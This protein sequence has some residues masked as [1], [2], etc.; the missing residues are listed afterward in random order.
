M[1]EFD[2]L[3][4]VHAPRSRRWLRLVSI[5]GAAA[6]LGVGGISLQTVFFAALVVVGGTWVSRRAE[7]RGV[8]ATRD[9]LLISNTGRGV[10]V[11]KDGSTTEIVRVEWED[12]H[13]YPD[14]SPP[15]GLPLRWFPFPKAEFDNVGTAELRL[16]VIP[17]DGGEWVSVEAARGLMPKRVRALAA[18]IDAEIAS[19]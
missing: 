8:W 15:S 13:R 17:G 18:A 3:R 9:E 4:V 6:L 1:D 19:R 12:A 11:P 10:R 2:D 14:P 5:A 16:F 7:E